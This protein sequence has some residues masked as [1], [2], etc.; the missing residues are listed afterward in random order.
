[1]DYAG[2]FHVKLDGRKIKIWL[3]LFTCL[4]SRAVNIKICDSLSE[5]S[6]L[7]ALQSHV[8]EEG[9][10]SKIFSDLGSQIVSAASNITN[11]LSGP[12]FQSYLTETGID[13]VKF[14]NYFKG[15]SSLGSLIE[16]CVKFTKKLIYSSIR[17]NVLFKPDFELLISKVKYL[18]NS[19]P[20]T[21]REGLRDSSS[22]EIPE[23][24]TPCVLVTG[25]DIS[26]IYVI[27]FLEIV[28]DEDVDWNCM[29]SNSQLKTE[30]SKLSR[31]H[32]KLGE[33]Y[34]KEFVANLVA[35]S[36]DKSGR[37]LHVNHCKL[38]VG[39]IVLLKRLI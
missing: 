32:S 14:E 15:N 12:T 19:R 33:I 29:G 39:D 11:F 25:R 4:W 35:Q 5:D 23:P 10:P 2:P 16:V 18:L 27:H 30:F 31:V 21:F 28:N 8:Y 22:S 1:M 36:V 37:Y 20:L 24:I 34:N 3:L 17:N 7:R 6:F 13:N 26:C 38:K 9:L